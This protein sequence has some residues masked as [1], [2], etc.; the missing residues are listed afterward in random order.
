MVIVR[1]LLD[2]NHRLRGW[3]AV[4]AKAAGELPKICIV[5]CSSS[6]LVSRSFSAADASMSTREYFSS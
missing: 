4:K 2:E 1:L 3:Q 6:V 5:C